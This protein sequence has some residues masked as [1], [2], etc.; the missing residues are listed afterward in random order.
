MNSE[1]L[2]LKNM[3]DIL[4][5]QELID[6]LGIKKGFLDKLRHKHRLPFCKIS[7]TKRV[8]LVHD[9]LNFI[10][11]KRLILNMGTD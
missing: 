6:L 5:E 11:S 8:Y 4:T 1:N 10:Q 7:N 9:V 2:A 3:N